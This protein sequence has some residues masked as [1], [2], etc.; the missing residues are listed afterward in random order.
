MT[1]RPFFETL[2]VL[3]FISGI[4]LTSGYF[5][6][7]EPVGTT[8]RGIGWF[9]LMMFFGLAVAGGLQL[10]R[11]MKKQRAFERATKGLRWKS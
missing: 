1:A 6:G 4:S 11:A 7:D 10:R 8:L 9:S 5:I 2:F 3:A